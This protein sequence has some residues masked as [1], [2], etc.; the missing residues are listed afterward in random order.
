[1]DRMY[2]SPRKLINTTAK[3]FCWFFFLNLLFYPNLKKHK[4]VNLLLRTMK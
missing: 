2:T 1:M 3:L 4:A